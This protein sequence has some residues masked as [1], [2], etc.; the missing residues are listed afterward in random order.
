M[1]FGSIPKM[2]RSILPWLISALVAF[3]LGAAL[4]V[5]ITPPTRSLWLLSLVVT[6]CGHWLAV[7]AA[8]VALAAFLIGG[9]TGRLAGAGS[10]A[11]VG[12][13]L[14]PLTQAFSIAG[15]LSA[16]L[17][18]A[19][20][21]NAS[22]DHATPLSLRRLFFGAAP[23]PVAVERLRFPT[24]D[25]S[26]L[27]LLYYRAVGRTHA[28]CVIVMHGGAWNSGSPDEFHA[29]SYHLARRGWNVAAVA[30]R[31]APKWQW[32]A[33]R[34]DMAAAVA[35]VKANHATL[36][37]DPTRL[38]LLGRSSGGHLVESYAYPA[39]DP[40]IRGLI[41]FYAP[42]DLNF[43][44]RYGDEND[45]LHSPQILRELLGGTP[46]QARTNYNSASPIDFVMASSPPT[47]LLHGTPD[48][49]VWI[50]QSRRLAERLQ[51]SGVRHCL[52]EL[53]WA[54]HGFDYFYDGPDGQISRAAIDHFLDTLG[55]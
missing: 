3:L 13:F 22:S 11:A 40:A 24:S 47:L 46:E 14:I 28:P 55:P 7:F 20:G 30:H 21:P 44:Y 45:I 18:A 15:G 51:Q 19:F 26:E 10:L 9:W 2:L 52:V 29:L 33:Q 25:A 49:L 42:A 35:W 38:V 16:K 5:V 41:A 12:L 48:P 27:D 32:P 50:R 54:T 36:D 53:P 34:D 23:D 4:L 17:A 43:A 39:N 37:L 31:F 6:E 8:V 1:T